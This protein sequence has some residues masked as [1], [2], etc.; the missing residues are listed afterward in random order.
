V[1]RV[2][3]KTRDF[4]Y[5]TTQCHDLLSIRPEAVTTTQ[6]GRSRFCIFVWHT[7]TALL[8]AFHFFADPFEATLAPTAPTGLLNGALWKP[9]I[10]IG[11][12]LLMVIVIIPV[13]VVVTVVVVVF[14]AAVRVATFQ[15]A[16][17]KPALR[18]SLQ[19]QRGKHWRLEMGCRL[20]P[21][22]EANNGTSQQ[23]SQWERFIAI[24]PLPAMKGREPSHIAP[25]VSLL[26]DELQNS[27]LKDNTVLPGE[28]IGGVIVLDAPAETNGSAN[29]SIDV[30]VRDEVH[31][32]A[33]S[34]AKVS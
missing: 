8:A 30:R 3:Q 6:F 20:R 23:C 29:Y 18:S 24:S 28:W 25:S 33:V 15:V 2:F 14:A 32:F 13:M 22:Y 31:T 27:I 4:V 9:G 34:Q 12:F 7:T 16:V 19:G 11:I 5:L 21:V 17:H 26:N 10:I 1:V